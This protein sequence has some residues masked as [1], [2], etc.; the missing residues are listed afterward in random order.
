MRIKNI[1]FSFLFS[2]LVNILFF[3]QGSFAQ[4]TWTS[5]GNITGVARNTAVAFTIGTKGYFGIGL[6]N[7]SY[8]QDF[9][10][11]DP[12]SNTWTQK[13]DFGGGPRGFA[14]GFSIGNFGY[15]GTGTNNSFV[16][17]FNDFWRYDPAANVW[18]QVASFG[19]TGRTTAAGFSIGNYGYLGTGNDVNGQRQDFWKFDPVGN[20]W[21]QLGNFA[22]G[23]RAD[24]DRAPFVIGNFAY[25]GTGANGWNDLWQY[26]PATDTWAQKANFPGPTRY[27]ATGFTLCDKGYL[28]LGS[29]G[30]GSPT[31]YSDYWQY[32]PV[33]NSWSAVTS[34]PAVGR[35]DAPAFVVNNKAYLGTGYGLTFYSDWWEFSMGSSVAISVTAS[36]TVICSGSSVTLTASGGNTYLWSNG[37]SATTIVVSPTVSTS[38]NVT[39]TTSACVSGGTV[40]INVAAQPTVTISGLATICSGN[41]AT[42]SATGGG[43]YSWSTGATASSIVAS[44]S[45]N[46]SYSVTVS[47]SCGTSTATTLVSVVSNVTANILCQNV[48]SGNIA[49]LS[50]S[51]GGNYTWSTGSTTSSIAT[52]SAGTYSVVVSLGTCSDTAA[53]TVNIFNSPTAL[54]GADVSITGGTST[55]L[56]ASGGTNYVW[57]TGESTASIS[58]SP[59]VTTSYTVVVTDANG[60]SDVD[61]VTVFVTSEPVNCSF[62]SPDEFAI[63][64]AF[65]PNGDSENDALKLLFKDISCIKE[66]TFTVY[67]R[68]GEEVFTTTNPID[69]WDGTY[70]GKKEESAVFAYY[71]KAVMLDKREIVKHGNVS[72]I[73]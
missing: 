61:S 16:T 35:C 33:A 14:V 26:D 36:S 6:S 45:A 1:Y 21:V 32:D 20:N 29:S 15:A 67:N 34:L 31:F 56:T 57:S 47:N 13:A 52:S 4:G 18:T 50:A 73:R 9:W 51:G 55:V 71:M 41:A 53:C 25:W 66:Y 54:A 68:W 62:S 22:G 59:A 60:C 37:S 24:V 64:N 38:Y 48:C 30:G 27:G 7:S 58:V 65:S 43:V 63:P 70:N 40:L 46:T 5:K 11:Y 8:V 44:P 23:T 28:G 69:E 2:I 39:D 17:W 49:T 72:L 12:A 42:L 3:I 19:G 10:E